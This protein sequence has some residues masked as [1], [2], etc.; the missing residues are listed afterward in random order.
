MNSIPLVIDNPVTFVY[1]EGQTYYNELLA[2]AILTH[3]ADMEDEGYE[4]SFGLNEIAWSD[5]TTTLQQQSALLDA[6]EESEHLD[7]G[8]KT[9]L[10]SAKAQAATLL[11]LDQN[12]QNFSARDAAIHIFESLFNSVSGLSSDPEADTD[13]LTVLKAAFL[14]ETI[15]GS[16][17]Y[18]T[19]TL[20]EI[21]ASKEQLEASKEQL[22][23]ILEAIQDLKYNDE[24]LEVPA[25]PRPI[26]IHLQGKTIQQ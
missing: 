1:T 20:D 13:L 21:E 7:A 8:W 6:L 2:H 15:P 22:E 14:R 24:I 4:I 18:T 26:R 16:G 12:Q 5:Q 9:R 23:T 3:A 17:V 11:N 25:T 10:T 19:T